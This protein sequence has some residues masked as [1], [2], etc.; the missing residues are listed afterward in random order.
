MDA[1]PGTSPGLTRKEA[2]AATWVNPE[3][4][5]LSEV[6]P[7]QKDRSWPPP[8]VA[9]APSRPSGGREPGGGPGLGQG[10]LQG[11][12]L[13][14]AGCGV[15]KGKS[16]LDGVVVAVAQQCGCPQYRGGARSEMGK[17]V[18]FALSGFR[19]D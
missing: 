17:V 19:Y 4:V 6:G 16:V 11:A 13:L 8:F 1:N 10:G 2:G 9:R 12:C 3:G 7:S 18:S 15:C 14:G 5:T